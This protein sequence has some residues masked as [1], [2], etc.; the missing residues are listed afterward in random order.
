MRL[1]LTK[2]SS[3]AWHLLPSSQVGIVI[4]ALGLRHAFDYEYAT[5]SA[6]LYTVKVCIHL[7]LYVF[8]SSLHLFYVIMFFSCAYALRCPNLFVGSR[9]VGPVSSLLAQRQL[10]RRLV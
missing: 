7:H 1:G 5:G 4:M 10:L 9:M 8:L 2:S 6:S 3:F